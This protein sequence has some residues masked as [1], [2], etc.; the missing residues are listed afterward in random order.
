M[1]EIR[2][3]RTEEM[4]NEALSLNKAILFKNSLMCGIS[5]HARTELESFA[6]ETEKDVAIFMIDVIN[7]RNIS[8]KIADKTGIRHESP[9]AIYMEQGVPVWHASHF[10]ITKDELEK[11]VR[12]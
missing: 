10:S 9:Q 11:A 6:R 12:Q 5:R 8:M 3:I 2:T 1:K 7:D 4:L